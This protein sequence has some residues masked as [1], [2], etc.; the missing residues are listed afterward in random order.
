MAEPSQHREEKVRQLK[1]HLDSNCFSGMLPPEVTREI[2]LRLE[3]YYPNLKPAVVFNKR[4]GKTEINKKRKSLKTTFY[5]QKI[6]L[7]LKPI[8][9]ENFVLIGHHQDLV[10]YKK[11]EHFGKHRDF[12]KYEVPGFFQVTI[13]IGLNDAEKGETRI[14]KDLKPTKSKKKSKK[15][16]QYLNF[17]ESI[18]TGGILIFKSNLPHA[19][20]P[21]KG[22]KEIL[23][24][25]GLCKMMTPPLIEESS[26]HSALLSK[27]NDSIVVPTSS[28]RDTIYGGERQNYMIQTEFELRD[29]Q[30]I[31]N[32]LNN[33]YT[34]SIKPDGSLW[35]KIKSI[36]LID[37]E[38]I[39]QYY[40]NRN[41]MV[42]RDYDCL[43]NFSGAYKAIIQS[44]YFQREG[45][46]ET[47]SK[48]IYLIKD[49]KLK[50]F[51]TISMTDYICWYKVSNLHIIDDIDSKIRE[52]INKCIDKDRF[53][54]LEFESELE[55][56]GDESFGI[57]QAK[58][59]TIFEQYLKPHIEKGTIDTSEEADSIL[60]DEYDDDD[61][62]GYL[63]NDEEGGGGYG[64]PERY[65]SWVVFEKKVILLPN[66]D[67]SLEKI[68]NILINW[69]LNRGY[70]EHKLGIWDNLFSIVLSYLVPNEI[71]ET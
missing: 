61:D 51:V 35:R 70:S 43:K 38:D 3:K 25:T 23:V 58:L 57:R 33:D 66:E 20:L 55:D 36:F 22:T 34:D 21:V 65:Y 30:K 64:T 5:D 19:G 49:N 10:Q 40:Y 59:F 39:L 54:D 31:C 32:F 4:T 37:I 68:K 28:L 52:L 44:N 27:T 56:E 7:L 26:K 24:L 16:K 41:I 67:I 9:P 29:L 53:D 62:D 63:C 50:Y 1:K 48:T 13:I 11:D 47:E 14:Y 17:N 8:L 60:I 2:K 6:D 42:I 71:T 12:I 46:K 18:T 69:H 15:N 45:Y